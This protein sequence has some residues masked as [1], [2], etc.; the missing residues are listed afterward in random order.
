MRPPSVKFMVN[1][2]LVNKCMSMH[3]NANVSLESNANAN[4]NVIFQECIQ[5]QMQMF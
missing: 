2:R 3:L 5:M 1:I 4:A